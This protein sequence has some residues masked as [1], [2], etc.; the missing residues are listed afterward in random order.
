MRLD[1]RHFEPS[2]GRDGMAPLPDGYAYRLGSAIKV[3]RGWHPTATCGIFGATLAAGRILGLERSRLHHAMGIAYSLAAGNF[4]AVVDGSLSKR[5]QPGFASRGAIEAVLLA[6]AGITGA[7][8]VFEGRFG[9]FPLYEQ[10]VC[11]F[12]HT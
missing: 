5:L 6:R 4:Q 2:M 12:V 10:R 11:A 7:K 1:G 9:Y 3:Y 8:D